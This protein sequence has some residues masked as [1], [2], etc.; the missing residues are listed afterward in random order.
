M[1]T[2]SVFQF[3]KEMINRIKVKQIL[4]I[5]AISVHAKFK[6]PMQKAYPLRTDLENLE[7][8]VIRLL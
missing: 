2:K 7:R 5:Q 4:E 8:E 6:S 1:L 3:T